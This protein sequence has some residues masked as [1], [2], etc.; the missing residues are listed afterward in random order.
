[1]MPVV[2]LDQ[3]ANTSYGQF[4]LEWGGS[5][6]VWDGNAD[7][8]FA[9]QQN[10]WIGAAVEGTVVVVLA[11]YGG[12]SAMR[13]ELW[14]EEPPTDL[15]WEDS[16]EVSMIVGPGD[17]IAWGTWT[18]AESGTLA[19]PPGSYRLRA[20]ARGRDAGHA[21]EFD[22][23]VVDYYLLQFWPAP[24]RPDAVV[25]TT[26]DNATYWNESWGSRRS[27]S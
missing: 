1:M 24:P 4:T 14:P 6:D 26:S 8:F 16:V 11:R 19:L 17:T 15:A 23:E 21:G 18:W 22:P 25:R 10:G 13:V 5:G 7:R 27:S 9:E 12:G 20:N 2:L 3:V